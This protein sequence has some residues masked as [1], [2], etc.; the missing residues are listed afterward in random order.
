MYNVI[1]WGVRVIFT[2]RLSEQPDTVA[3]EES[4]FLAI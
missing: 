2:H 3:L 4:D 1:L